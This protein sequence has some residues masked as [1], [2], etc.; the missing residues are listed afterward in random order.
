MIPHERKGGGE[1]YS[2][3]FND[4]PNHEVKSLDRAMSDDQNLCIMVGK[5]DSF[6]RGLEREIGLFE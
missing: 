1:C 2:C 3:L 5:K 4:K 6:A